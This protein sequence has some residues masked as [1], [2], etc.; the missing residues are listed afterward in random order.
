[1]ADQGVSGSQSPAAFASDHFGGVELG[2]RRLTR[3]AE[4]V[5]AAIASCPH[6]S[7][8]RQCGDAHQ[9]KG[10][11]RLFDHDA[12]TS[13][14]ISRRHRDLTLDAA[15]ERD[16][17]V[18]VQDTTELSFAESRVGVG[19]IGYGEGGH[20][21]LMHSTLAITPGGVV[22]GL[23]ALK[24]WARGPARRGESQ[25]RRRAR[26]GRESLRW[27]EAIEA[28]GAPPA[29]ATWI[30][31]GDRE[32][33]VWE[34]FAAALE[35]GSDCVIRACGAA[36]KRK[37]AIGHAD[38]PPNRADA[39]PLDRLARS[40]PQSGACEV[41]RQARP[42]VARGPMRLR[43]SFAPVTML[44]PRL[45]GGEPLRLWVV[46]AWS[47]ESEWVIVTTL[48]VLDVTD[49]LEVV[50]HY[51][52]RWTIEEYHK[53]L[54]TGCRVEERQLQDRRRLEPLVAMLAIVALRLL[55]LRSIAR[56]TPAAP[57]TDAVPEAYV[58]VLSKLRG[59][60]ES[61]LTCRRFWRETARLG[62]F[63]ARTS[64]GDPGWKTL[65]LGWHDLD[66]I[67]QGAT[68]TQPSRY[69]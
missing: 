50:D 9:A 58:R 26:E 31:V 44:P 7:L 19:P 41:T 37:A 16:V 36:A 11:Y 57:A 2:D 53:C 63:L 20:G 30:H 13:Q 25:A 39:T 61:E 68:I 62:G 10:A 60:P 52:R 40:L 23:A 46:R 34:T 48:P 65:W 8:P 56:L 28:V 43:V 49:A 18:F 33:D 69:G 59:I 29:G 64:D 67:V 24:I 15:R 1:M 27:K 14:S 22:L 51:R 3:R 4:R 42:G 5:A 54:K 6:A 17:V 47:D 45:V 55:N 38:E 35:V 12:V 21:L 32:A 66:L